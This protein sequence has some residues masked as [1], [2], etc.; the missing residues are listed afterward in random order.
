M[1]N[2]I[3]VEVLASFDPGGVM[4]PVLLTWEDG[5]TYEIDRI[6]DI[7]QAAAMKAGGSGDRYTVRIKGKES[8]L[9]FERNASLRGNNIGRWF[10]ER[11]SQG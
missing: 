11:K 5:H 2:K 4:L 9:F 7:R 8:F 6:V 10:V 1:E 3:Y